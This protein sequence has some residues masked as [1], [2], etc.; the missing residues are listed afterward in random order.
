MSCHLDEI[1]RDRFS[2]LYRDNEWV[3]GMAIISEAC[4][5][6]GDAAAAP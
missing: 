1:A 3:L 5:T 2:V 6:L 4:A